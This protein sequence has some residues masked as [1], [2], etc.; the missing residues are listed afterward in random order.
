[1]S[2]MRTP[3]LVTR[4][5][6]HGVR[7]AAD[8]QIVTISPDGEHRQ[9]YRALRARAAKLAHALRRLGVRKG[10]RVATL[11][12]NN[13][14]HL[15]A[16]YAVPGMGA[17]LH[18][19]N[20]RLPSHELEYV[21]NHA[22]SRVLLVDDDLLDLVAPSLARL[23]TIEHVVVST[24]TNARALEGLGSLDWEELLS[25]EPDEFVWPEDLDEH[26][27]MGLCYTS[28]TTGNPK[29]VMYTHRSTYLHTMA[30]AMTDAVGLSAT[31]CVL[32]VVPMFH[33]LGWGYPYSATMLGAKQVLL[34]GHLR[35]EAMLDAIDAEQVTFSAGV[36]T[37]WQ[38][39]QA[40]I[41]S[42]PGRWKLA[43]LA[44]INCGASA[45]APSL[46]RWYWDNLGVEM[47][48]TWGM[49]EANPLG[50]TSRK[51][52][53]HEHVGL[54][55]DRQF[56]NVS[57]TGLPLPGIELKLVD[58]AGHPVPHDGQT[59]GNL[60]IRGPWVCS[61]YY[62]NPQPERFEAGW[63]HTGDVAKID[64]AGYLII[65]DRSKDL[66]KSGGE[67]IS[68]IDL[69]NHILALPGVLQAAVVAQP[70]PKWGERP[71]A[72]VVRSPQADVDKDRLISHCA[73]KFAKWQLPD[74]VLFVQELPLN[75]TGKLD[76]RK[77]RETLA[78]QG[79]RL[80][81]VKSG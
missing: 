6:E 36:P 48:Q 4:L 51:V 43:T 18:T 46:I 12:S 30:Q 22:E 27:P 9:S 10:D 63:L 1:M 8:E 67:W 78:D 70:H 50:V 23:P 61:E 62:R 56:A 15:E 72:M 40:A 77:I 66:I 45:P 42:N 60:M 47:I 71:I 74:D 53:K 13:H 21:I 65:T 69:E 2:M 35:V 58:D 57:K 76:K 32:Q 49:T 73:A 80:P 16:F 31:D 25:P 5:M 59:P 68:S 64:P 55:D 37:V 29:G 44:R 75:S 39:A 41:E 81:D 20:L 26:A 11:M 24:S 34:Q 52:A 33:V 28:G 3:L 17:V 54:D 38:S 14:R 7:R 19:L 79:Y